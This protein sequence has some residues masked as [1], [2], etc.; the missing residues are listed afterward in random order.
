MT[1]DEYQYLWNKHHQLKLRVLA[2]RIY[3]QERQR[4]FEFREGIIKAMSIIAGTVAF[5]NVTNQ[6]LLIIKWCLFLITAFNIFALVFG[7]G[8]KA[9]DSGKRAVDWTLLERDMEIVGE[10]DFTESQ[11]NQWIAR[12]NEIEAGEP[13]SHHVLMEICTERACNSLGG[14]YSLKLSCFQKLL[15]IVFIP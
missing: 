4:R 13:A 11:L 2:N 5:A 12:C 15:P 3:Q 1:S 7:Y 14:E 8:N 6:N 9:R 10:R